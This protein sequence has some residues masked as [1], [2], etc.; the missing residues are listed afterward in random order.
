MSEHTWIGDNHPA[1]WKRCGSIDVADPADTNWALDRGYRIGA[2]YDGYS[3]SCAEPC[4][5]DIYRE[6]KEHPENPP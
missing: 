3:G 2:I 4:C 6:M 5:A 1:G